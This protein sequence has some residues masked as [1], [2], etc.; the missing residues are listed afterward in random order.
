MSIAGL[1]TGSSGCG[2]SAFVDFNEGTPAKVGDVNF[3]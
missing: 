2:A 3:V 1:G